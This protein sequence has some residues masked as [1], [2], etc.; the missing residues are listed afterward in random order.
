MNQPAW[1]QEKQAQAKEQP[2]QA[3]KIRI[4]SARST[5]DHLGIFFAIWI[6]SVLRIK[7]PKSAGTTVRFGN[8]KSCAS[9]VHQVLPSGRCF[10]HAFT[11]QFCYRPNFPSASG[12]DGAED[13]FSKRPLH[14]WQVSALFFAT[15]LLALAFPLGIAAQTNVINSLDPGQLNAALQAGG[16]VTFATN[17]T[18]VLTNTITISNNV[19]LDGTNH[20]ITIS[21]GGAVE[22]FNLPTGLNLTLRN[23]ILADGVTN[24]SFVNNG[25]TF[26]GAGYGGAIFTLG[27]LDVENCTFTNNRAFGGAVDENEQP[28]S[29]GSGGAIYS[30]GW[31]SISNSSFVNNIAAGSS[32]SGGGEIASGGNGYGGAICN[33]GGT[34]ELQNVSFLSNSVNGVGVSGGAFANIQG[35]AYGG[36]LYSS[37]GSLQANNLSFFGNRAS[38]AAAGQG[39][40]FYLLGTAAAISNSVFSNNVAAEGAGEGVGGAIVN[41]GTVLLWNCDLEGSIAQGSSG[42]GFVGAVASPAYGGAI[43]NAGTMQIFGTTISYSSANGGGLQGFSVG[44]PA[45]GLGGAVYNTG[46]LKIDGA[47]LSKNQAAGGSGQGFYGPVYGNGW[48]GAIYN[49]GFVLL[50]STILSSNIASGYTIFAEEIYSSGV[51]QADANSSLIPFVTGTPPLIFQW[52]ENGSNI[53]G[54]TNATLDLG[55]VP[56]AYAG[57]YDLVI[58]NVSGL[59]TNFEE[60]VDLPPPVLTISGVTPN[61]GLTTGGTSVTI[62][63]TG[64]TNGATVFFGNAAATSVT[65]VSATNITASTPPAAIAGAVNATVV[66]P[67][68][69][70]AVLTK[71][72]TYGAPVSLSSPQQGGTLGNGNIATFTLTVGGPGIPGYNYV[73]ESSTD[74]VNWQSLQ[75]NSS[76]FTFIDTNAASYPI[77]FYRAVLTQ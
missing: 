7:T 74:L 16:T 4:P 59:V 57:T 53:L 69:E 6:A 15:I 3:V 44:S 77:R 47:N 8:F 52:Q 58:S 43:Y 26:P 17:G 20:S 72:F 50:S 10:L 42:G 36:A 66:N 76:P 35:S 12:C 34:L 41:T 5:R 14:G 30:A 24:G 46:V 65:V 56:F 18:I 1:R 60:I 62:T 28:G 31:L 73:I 38:G 25:M 49:T 23:L 33:D 75:T 40:A 2:V 70:S 21:G 45:D 22:L 51:I 55:S 48:G 64:F 27:T 32:G 39:G 19:I 61:T 67:D 54:S 9:P 63:G 13:S 68:F 11:H 29:P 71:G 37:G